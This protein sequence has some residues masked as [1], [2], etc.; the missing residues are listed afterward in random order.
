MTKGGQI[1]VDTFH[2]VLENGY[3][4]TKERQHQI[5]GYHL[6]HS[7]SSD[8]AQVY[9]NPQT[10]K[11]IVSHRGTQGLSDWGNNIAYKYGLYEYTP[12]YR[13]AKKIQK[14]TEKKY[15]ASTI[16]TIGHSQ[17]A[18][19]AEK[20]GKKTK[21]VITYNRPVLAKDMLKKTAKN[22]TDI[23]TTLDPVSILQPTQ[24]TSQ[25]TITIPST[26]ADPLKE[27]STDALTRIQPDMLLGNGLK[28]KRMKIYSSINLIL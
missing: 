1:N 26:S 5:N 22:H 19:L 25:S 18:M 4:T 28:K 14:Q 12:R 11:A 7:L 16:D 9:H 23:R 13:H 21:N 15:G 27:H 2:K 6:D 3:K 8:Y 10:N 17:G 24:Q 20:L